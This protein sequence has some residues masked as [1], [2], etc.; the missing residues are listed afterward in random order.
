M[1]FLAIRSVKEFENLI[2]Y[3]KNTKDIIIDIKS[4][5]ELRKLVECYNH[6]ENRVKELLFSPLFNPVRTPYK[7]AA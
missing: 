3:P 5:L 2:K 7:I 4:S 6:I 1:A